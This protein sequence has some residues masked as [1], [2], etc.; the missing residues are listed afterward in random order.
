MLTKLTQKK[1]IILIGF[2]IILLVFWT[3][4]L[5]FGN[6]EDKIIV[7]V[8]SLVLPFIIYGFVRLMFKIVNINASFKAMRFFLWFFLIVGT[9]GTIIMIVEYITGF[10]NGL[11][12]T[13]GAC[14]G[15]IIAVLDEIKK[16]IEIED[17]Q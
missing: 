4:T 17:K 5:L 9:L 10:P 13:L 7:L 6:G 14:L 15:L 11:S 12:P 8:L 1:N 2:A 3:L 16:S